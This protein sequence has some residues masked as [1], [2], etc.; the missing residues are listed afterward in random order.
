M[1][2]SDD[3]R[4]KIATGRIVVWIIVGGIGLYLVVSGLI[5]IITKG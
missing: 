1:S 5:G 3:N 2:D 4:K